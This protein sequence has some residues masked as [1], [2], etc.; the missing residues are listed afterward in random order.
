MPEAQVPP[1]SFAAPIKVACPKCS[2]PMALVVQSKALA[3][4]CSIL[5]PRC[6]CQFEILNGMLEATLDG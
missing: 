4:P 3:V 5:C 6:G 1:K 2:R